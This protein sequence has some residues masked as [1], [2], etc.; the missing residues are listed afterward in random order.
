MED[1]I[2]L[3]LRT[4]AARSGRVV[5]ISSM[6][7][8][9][10]FLFQMDVF[11][12]FYYEARRQKLMRIRIIHGIGRGKLK[13]EILKFLKERSEVKNIRDGFPQEGFEGATIVTF[14]LY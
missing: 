11:R 12:K 4:L 3:H 6:T 9:E 5:N 10:K 1:T 7:D 8:H 14:N 13:S 2:D